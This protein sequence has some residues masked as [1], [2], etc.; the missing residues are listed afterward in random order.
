MTNIKQGT[1]PSMAASISMITKATIKN[2]KDLESVSLDG[3]KNVNIVIGENASGKTSLLEALFLAT[4]GS[5]EI[6]L[7]FKQWR[8][9]D[10][11]ASF[12]KPSFSPWDDLFRDFNRDN[13]I[14]ISIDDKNHGKRK[15]EV[16]YKPDSGDIVFVGDQPNA[17]QF[18]PSPITFLWNVKGVER[19]INPRIGPSG[20]QFTSFAEVPVDNYFF[21][22]GSNFSSSETAIRFSALSQKRKEKDIVDIFCREFPQIEGLGIEIYQGGT[23]LAASVRGKD[24]KIPLPLISGGINKLSSILCA[25]SLTENSVVFID[26]VENGFHFKKFPIL[27]RTIIDLA[28]KSNSQVFISTHSYECLQAAADVAKADPDCFSVIRMKDGGAEQFAG[29][30]FVDA[31]SEEIEIR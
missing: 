12:G 31:I 8:G 6:A 24:Q 3:C 15:L 5:P 10:P 19:E 13:T 20:L 22:S 28:K 27:W 18:I 25:I 21:A 7:R 9:F 16:R 29:S 11:V 1:Q 4:G 14:E 23:V 30:S 17:M 26:E 2:F